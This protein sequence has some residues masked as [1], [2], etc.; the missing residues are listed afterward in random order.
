V[1]ESRGGALVKPFELIRIIY[2]GECQYCSRYAAYQRL[3]NSSE[4]VNLVNVRDLPTIVNDLDI[5]RISPNWG[6]IVEFRRRGSE[7]SEWLSGR[8]AMTVLAS[9]D[10]GA[11]FLSR[12][13]RIMMIPIVGSLIYPFLW[14]GRFLTLLFL[15]RS[16]YI[17]SNRS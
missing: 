11:N 5:P 6:I 12:L 16:P 8:R 17:P 3:T 14:V 2:D 13:H 10:M 15:L 4:V 7:Y 9:L 1:N